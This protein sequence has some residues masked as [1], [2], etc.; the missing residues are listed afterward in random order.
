MLLMILC[1][2]F[3]SSTNEI[4]PERFDIKTTQ[5]EKSK[6]TSAYVGNWTIS[7]GKDFEGNSYQG[8]V[9]ITP[10]K[11]AYRVKWN[12]SAT[13]EGIGIMKND[14]LFIGWGIDT[15]CGIAVY[16]QKGNVL[17]GIWTDA[18]QGGVLGEETVTI[19]GGLIGT[20]KATGVNPQD[21]QPYR[22]AVRIGQ[23]GDV[24][25]FEWVTGN[26]KFN[27]VGRKVGNIIAIGWGL[28]NQFGY[29]DYKAKD[30]GLDGKWAIW[31]ANRFA[32]EILKK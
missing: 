21:K 4:E 16:E 25:T 10:I 7:E 20:H 24:Y 31:G 9:D 22:A 30:G 18:T 26:V 1:S 11:S 28:S 14:Q 15:K 3:D 29:V 5:K 6:E 2:C 19:S 13:Y 27:G 12:V 23:N 17:E 8:H 32:T